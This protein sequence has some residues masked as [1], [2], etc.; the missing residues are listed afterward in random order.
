[1]GEVLAQP[2]AKSRCGVDAEVRSRFRQ[3]E[4]YSEVHS[5]ASI[6]C[7]N[8][9]VGDELCQLEQAL[10]PTRRGQAWNHCDR[11]GFAHLIAHVWML[12]NTGDSGADSSRCCE[13][14]QSHWCSCPKACHT[15]M[16]ISPDT[17]SRV[18]QHDV[19][20]KLAFA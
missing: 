9:F 13:R 18:V 3:S 19:R 11:E 4:M 5:F 6:D 20:R 2:T 14:A 16:A 17:N 1:S 12:N 10:S 7:A 15:D 8:C